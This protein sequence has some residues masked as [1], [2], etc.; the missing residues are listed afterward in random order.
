MVEVEANSL[1]FP[2]IMNPLT[3]VNQL[4]PPE[5]EMDEQQC[6]QPDPETPTDNPPLCLFRSAD[7]IVRVLNSNPGRDLCNMIIKALSEACGPQGLFS[8]LFLDDQRGFTTAPTRTWDTEIKEVLEVVLRLHIKGGDR[9]FFSP[10][11][12]ELFRIVSPDDFLDTRVRAGCIS[13]CKR[14]IRVADSIKNAGVS[15]ALIPPRIRMRDNNY[16][17]PAGT[18]Q[19]KVVTPDQLPPDVSTVHITSL[20]DATSSRKDRPDLFTPDSSANPFLV[21]IGLMLVSFLFA[22]GF[23]MIRKLKPIPYALTKRYSYYMLRVSWNSPFE[24]FEELPLRGAGMELTIGSDEA[25]TIYSPGLVAGH[26]KVK[27]S[28]DALALTCY[29]SIRLEDGT[30]VETSGKESAVERFPI[31][32]GLLFSVGEAVFVLRRIK[33]KRNNSGDSEPVL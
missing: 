2:V 31:N 8:L 24:G 26:I 33:Y 5:P 21:Q 27:V 3:I 25:D 16:Q 4:Y 13:E 1:I 9:G 18:L 7:I 29:D 22:G 28:E 15:P 32:Q 19:V 14:V 6:T 11:L 20:R 17:S 12:E 23:V 30:V 10:L